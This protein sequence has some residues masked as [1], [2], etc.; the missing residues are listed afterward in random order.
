MPK[1][2]VAL[3]SSRPG[4]VDISLRGLA[5]QTFQDFEVVFVDA[6][7]HKRHAEVLEYAKKVGLK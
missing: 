2:T 3:G 6:R 7:Y 5:D 4:G 1:V